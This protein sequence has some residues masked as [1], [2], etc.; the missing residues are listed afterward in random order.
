MTTPRERVLAAIEHRNR[1]RIPFTLSAGRSLAVHGRS[2]LD[3][4]RRFPNDFYDVADLKIPAMADLEKTRRQTDIWGCVWET[5]DVLISGAVVRHPLADWDDFSSY[6]MPEPPR[7]TDAEIENAKRQREKYPVWASIQQF[8]QVMENLRGAENLYADFHEAPERVQALIDRLWNGYHR[9]A[10]E[11]R[12]RLRPDIVGLGD[13]WGTQQNLLISP[14]FWRGFFKPVYRKMM[15]IVH[16]GG[17]KAYFHTCGHT[18]AI[19][20]DF[21]E[22]GLDIVNPQ[23]AIM[24]AREYGETARGRITILP[25]LDRQRI[26]KQGSPAEV[27]EHVRGLYSLLGTPNGGLIGAAPLEYDMPLENIRALMEVVADYTP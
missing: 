20:G 13:D 9:P 25:D 4:L 11:E 15:E 3:L 18:R 6:R 27:R 2:L 17:G 24:D 10:L 7:A 16:Q 23:T 5:A 22:I 21:I 12:M 19:L 8:F 26:L 1:G 14:E